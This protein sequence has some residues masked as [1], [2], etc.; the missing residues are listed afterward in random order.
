MTRKGNNQ[1]WLSNPWDPKEEIQLALSYTARWLQNKKYA[2]KFITKP[3]P[4]LRHQA[5]MVVT[6]KITNNNANSIA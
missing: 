5:I 6:T 2:K 3:D 4:N 1:R